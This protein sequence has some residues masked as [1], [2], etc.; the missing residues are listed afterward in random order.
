[1]SKHAVQLNEYSL[2]QLDLLR[3][4]G[5]EIKLPLTHIANA[6]SM[7][8][9]GSYDGEEMIGQ[10]AL[11]EQTSRR[12][13]QLVDGILFASQVQTEQ[14]AL[15]PAPTNIASIAY[16][17]VQEL[18]PIAGLYGKRLKL[19]ITT[20]LSPAAV[21]RVALH[22]SLYGLLDLLIRTSQTEEI[23]LLVHHQTDSVMVS[24]RSYGPRFSLSAVRKSLRH[25]GVATQP[26][27][28]IPNSSGMALFVA[29]ALTRAMGGNF[30]INQSAGR[31]TI[32]IKVP[33]SAQLTLI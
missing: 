13:I 11:L 20:E 2:S 33:L 24:L 15:T 14:L 12:M 32:A 6:A 16:R 3:I 10:H 4:V 30:L 1:M 25:M 8:A 31:R 26:I 17:A 22:H 28:H 23:E 9:A 29:D 19:T 7:L 27:R 18:H 21:D 5:Y